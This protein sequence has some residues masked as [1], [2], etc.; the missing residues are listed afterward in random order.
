MP[1]SKSAPTPAHGTGNHGDVSTERDT[2]HCPVISVLST[3]SDMFQAMY[4]WIMFFCVWLPYKLFL[5]VPSTIV[6]DHPGSR[7]YLVGSVAPLLIALLTA[8]LSTFWYVLVTVLA[9]PYIPLLVGV[10]FINTMILCGQV[11]CVSRTYDSSHC[12]WV[13]HCH[14]KECNGAVVGIV[15]ANRCSSHMMELASMYVSPHM[16]GQGLGWKLMEKVTRFARAG[17][18]SHV[19][20]F[21]SE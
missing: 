8:P 19:T 5:R 2:R 10:C 21:T 7:L 6:A 3:Y 13:A 4:L 16:R 9:I 12:F 11:R 18:C 15:R 17:G 20:L 14:C 1:S